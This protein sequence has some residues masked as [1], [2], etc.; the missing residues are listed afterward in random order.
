MKILN[1]GCYTLSMCVAA[2]M[3][4]GCGGSAGSG[5]MPQGRAMSPARVIAHDIGVASSYN[6]IYN[7][8]GFPDGAVPCA[9]LLDE[10]G[11]LYGTTTS[12]GTHFQR[13]GNENGTVFSISTT[14]TEH[15]LY[16]F[17]RHPDGRHPCAGLVDMGGT[18]YGTTMH[19]GKYYGGTVFSISTTGKEHVLHSFAGGSSD[20]AGPDASLINVNGTLYGTTF[21][22]GTHNAGT[23][24]SIST[25]GSVHVL[26]SFGG[27]F[28]GANP[29]ASLIGAGQKLYG[30]T[31]FGGRYGEGTVFS[32]STTGKEH[33]LHSFGSGS[34]G[35][36]PPASL[37]DV[38]GTLYGTTEEGGAYAAGTIFSI[39]TGGTERVLHS[40]GR[41][42]DGNVPTGGL[43]DVGGTLY[44]GT[45]YGT[46]FEGGAYG[47]GTVFSITTGGTEQVLH[48]FG[49][50]SDGE[51]P[52]ASL[53]D[54]NG[55]LY[56]TTEAGGYPN[57]DGT[58]FALSP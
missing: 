30:T 41:G 55:T 39:T 14:G 27:R 53:T 18:L 13:Y 45:L 46:T 44:S 38:K 35:Q 1:L 34:D 26:Y 32:T 23:I 28:D 4:S 3:L 43:I 9:S 19:G 58:V 42:S 17:S 10:N 16:R 2:V 21:Y 5:A 49:G 40:F 36:W 52:W 33:R 56:G 12:G 57:N 22:G 31:L 20:G 8:R 29:D 6:V 24:F 37:I 7:F 54:V 25:A 48:S 50:G 11:T 51:K 15:V 47:D